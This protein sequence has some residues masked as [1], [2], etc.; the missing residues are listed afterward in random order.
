M[1]HVIRFIFEKIGE[2]IGFLFTIDM[3]F[4]S[5]GTFFCCLSFGVPT[6]LLVFNFLKNKLGG[7]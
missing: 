4:M 3:G 2:F 7:D 6:V 1:L 5:V